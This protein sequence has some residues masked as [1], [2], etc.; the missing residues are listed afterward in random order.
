MTLFELIANHETPHEFIE[1][2]LA[3]LHSE[4]AFEDCRD[5]FA[6]VAFWEGLTPDDDFEEVVDRMVELIEAEFSE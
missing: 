6:E 4:N 1:D 3:N 5:L 2:C